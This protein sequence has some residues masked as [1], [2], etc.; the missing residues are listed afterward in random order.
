MLVMEEYTFTFKM[1]N[2]T[3]NSGPERVARLTPPLN[4]AVLIGRRTPA[5]EC[6]LNDTKFLGKSA[7][8]SLCKWHHIRW[9]KQKSNSFKSIANKQQF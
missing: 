7:I 4:E 9:V 8:L 1:V 3:K 5:A 6:L 2:K